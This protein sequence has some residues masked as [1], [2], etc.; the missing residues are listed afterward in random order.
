MLAPVATG[1]VKLEGSSD[2]KI[3]ALDGDMRYLAVK[4]ASNASLNPA[5]TNQGHPVENP[6]VYLPLTLLPLPTMINESQR[7]LRLLTSGTERTDR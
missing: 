1:V 7:S 3:V 6:S 2:E 5:H 4:V